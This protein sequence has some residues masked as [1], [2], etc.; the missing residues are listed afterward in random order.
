[1]LSVCGAPALAWQALAQPI[2]E[3]SFDRNVLWTCRDNPSFARPD[4]NVLGQGAD[5]QRLQATLT[6]TKVSKRLLMFHVHF[7]EVVKLQQ[8]T[9]DLFYGRPP[10]HL[11]NTFKTSVR[12]ILAAETW[13]DFFNICHRSCPGPSRLT[14]ILKQAV[15]NS[16]QKRYH[17]DK[18]DFSRIQASGVSHILKKGETYKLSSSIQHVRL[19][20]GSDSA[21]ILCGACLMYE[22]LTCAAVVSYDNCSSYNGAVEH[23]G[24]MSVNGRS[25]HVLNVKVGLLPSS[26]TRLFFTLCSCGCTDLSGFKSPTIDMRDEGNAAPLC[27]YSIE[28]AGRAPT[29][30]MAVMTRISGGWQVTA[31]GVHSAV[32]CCGNYSQV[33]RDI[34]G[35]KF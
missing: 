17:S 15:K 9:Q 25:K 10:H 6:S 1:L 8:N 27:T 31:L 2:F 4:R 5:V 33:K 26:V 28:K 13:P 35:I 19:E 14:D 29:V 16:R 30:V 22:D 34:A 3:E 12:T 7:L 23:S 20:L 18:T 11:R 32:R 21:N 24:D